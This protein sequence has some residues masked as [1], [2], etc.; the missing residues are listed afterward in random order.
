[1]VNRSKD[2]K[3]IVFARDVPKAFLQSFKSL[4]H[5]LYAPPQEF[6]KYFPQNKNHIWNDLV[7][8]Y[9][10]VKAGLYWYKTFIPWLIYDPCFLYSPTTYLAILLFTDDLLI[11]IIQ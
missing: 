7:Q 3:I 5:I 6:Y 1:M 4:R 11:A 8:L 2:D 9:G 10:E